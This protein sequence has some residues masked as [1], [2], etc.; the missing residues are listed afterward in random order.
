MQARVTFK[1]HVAPDLRETIHSNLISF[2]MV[3]VTDEGLLVV[4]V[5]RLSRKKR[6][7][8]SLTT[9]E[10]AGWVSYEMIP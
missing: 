9:Y 10:K 6:L 3:T 1:E 4:E 5:T 2:A 8:A 7:S